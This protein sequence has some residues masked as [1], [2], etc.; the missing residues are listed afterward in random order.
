MM[1]VPR[2]LKASDKGLSI[3]ALAD[4]GDYFCGDVVHGRGYLTKW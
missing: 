3:E 2:Y 4:G 1:P